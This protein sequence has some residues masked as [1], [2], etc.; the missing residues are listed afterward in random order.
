MADPNLLALMALAMGGGA[1]GVLVALRFRDVMR[2][3]ADTGPKDECATQA[4]IEDEAIHKAVAEQA[5]DGLVY[6]DMQAR[7]L[8]ANPAYCR[9]MGVE[10]D[11]I[12]G[13]R[14]QE[15]CFPPEVKPSDEDIENFVFDTEDSEFQKLTRRLNIRANGERFWH[16]FNLSLTKS[17]SG[18]DRVILV[19]RDVNEQVEH[20]L[21]LERA[22]SEL[23]Y[24]A[25]HDA[26]TGL[27][28]RAAFLEDASEV[29]EAGRS[30]GVLY[31]DLDR[32]KQINDSL[33]HAAGD[34]VLCHVAD[35]IQACCLG[36]EFACRLGGDEFLLASPDAA[37]LEELEFI[38]DAL[39]DRI[40]APVAWGGGDI[41]CGASIGIAMGESAMADDII[42]AADFALYDAKAIGS[43][44]IA[45]YDADLHARQEAEKAVLSEF[46]D[47]LDANALDFAFQPLLDTRTGSIKSFETL[48]R[49]RRKDGTMVPPDVF[50]GYARRLNRLADID[51]AA[52]TA[53]ADLAAAFKSRDQDIVAGFNTSPETLANPNFRKR[54]DDTLT[55][56][57]LTPDRLIVEILETTFFGADASGSP[58]A[59]QITNLRD[60][61]FTV[62]LDDFGVGYAGLA[63][64][65]QLDV[66]G[67][68]L[69][70]SLITHI[71]EDQNA[72][73]I[74][75][76]ILHLCHELGM[77][78]CAEGVETAEQAEILVSHGCLR[79]QGFGIAKPMSFEEAL[80]F[81][82]RRDI[83]LP[84]AATLKSA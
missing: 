74:A 81:G 62:F 59:K 10:L 31:I 21:A 1:F 15:F 3:G 84:H 28:N 5:N 4:L 14:P 19:S 66:S 18:E 79:L 77:R 32:F 55:S 80:T 51:F 48:A 65:G 35:A 67:I 63:H 47:T 69:D 58:A 45:R 36:R 72:R 29:L 83:A 53:A 26:L 76:S 42:K 27:K 30:L 60:S 38:A 13:R 44:H 7:I 43:P 50:L 49:W 17:P 57:D 46:V 73:T 75:T 61:G 54:L 11:E 24:S 8:W 33:G 2:T 41:Q 20:E 40:L 56:K 78:T 52:I 68:K 82:E 39:R 25:T 16:E 23:A 12:I 34:A 70:R 22:R 9:I 64:L 37:D 6:H 71:V